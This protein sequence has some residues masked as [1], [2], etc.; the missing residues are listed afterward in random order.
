MHL[1]SA[2]VTKWFARI[3]GHRCQAIVTG[4]AQKIDDHGFGEVVHGVAREDP[5]R[6]NPA[7]CGAGARLEIGTRFDG[8]VMHDHRDTE[9]PADVDYRVGVVNTRRARVVV[10][11]VHRD[12]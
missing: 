6:Q 4:P 8:D 2:Q 3:V 11:V 1:N 10:N 12:P 7:A 9:G 5:G